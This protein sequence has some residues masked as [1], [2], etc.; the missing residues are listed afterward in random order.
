VDKFSKNLAEKG[1]KG[2]GSLQSIW[3]GRRAGKLFRNRGRNIFRPGK[4]ISKYLKLNFF[5]KTRLGKSNNLNS[6]K[7][8]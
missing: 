8:N 1:Y 5:K 3:K 2:V 6:V 7:K 4:S